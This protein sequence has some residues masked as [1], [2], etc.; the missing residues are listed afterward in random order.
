M[1][2]ATPLTTDGLYKICVKLAV[3]NEYNIYISIWNQQSDDG[4]EPGMTDLGELVRLSDSNYEN[5]RPS[6][7]IDCSIDLHYVT[8]AHCVFGV[9]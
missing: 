1:P 6:N 8:H 3:A 5:M 2:C 9:N 7:T 4:Y